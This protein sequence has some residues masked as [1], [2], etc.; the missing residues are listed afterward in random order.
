MQTSQGTQ[1]NKMLLLSTSKDSVRLLGEKCQEILRPS[2]VQYCQS[3]PEVILTCC[4]AKRGAE[5]EKPV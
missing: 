2:V 4:I 3:A 5:P 1:E